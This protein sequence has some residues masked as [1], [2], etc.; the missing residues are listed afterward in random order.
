[1]R[2][3]V[4]TRR[5]A[6]ATASAPWILAV[7]LS[8]TTCT[9]TESS[10]SG[11]PAPNDQDAAPDPS[12][13]P[14]RAP[15]VSP[16]APTPTRTR[17]EP[18]VLDPLR[19]NQDPARVFP[20]RDGPRQGR[21]RG[22]LA[23]LE[24]TLVP[25]GNELL[26]R[27]ANTGKR[28]VW[29]CGLEAHLSNLYAVDANGGRIAK[30]G[31]CPWTKREEPRGDACGTP[32]TGTW[33]LA[34]GESLLLL[35]ARARQ[36]DTGLI[37]E[38]HDTSDEPRYDGTCI[39]IDRDRAFIEGVWMENTEQTRDDWCRPTAKASWDTYSHHRRD[40]PW[41]APIVGQW[42]F[43]P[44]RESIDQMPDRGHFTSNRV[45]VVALREILNPEP[46]EG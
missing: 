44:D 30:V 8:S 37:L 42:T 35:R 28:R 25:A 10:T 29:W 12:P 31:R 41:T 45:E 4:N 24:L 17:P 15:S 43:P 26:L 21:G 38:L 1:M 2:G 46:P 18:I 3:D 14:A 22:G 32:A 36:T 39:V 23:G 33:S 7:L 6:A 40:E 19:F 13:P 9:G 27:I 5:V 11:P 34:P 16:E 20:V